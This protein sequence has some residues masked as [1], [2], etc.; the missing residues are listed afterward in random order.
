MADFANTRDSPL[1]GDGIKC[2]DWFAEVNL[3][4]ERG[5][6]M[7]EITRVGVDLAKAVIQVWVPIAI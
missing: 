4:F 2:R 7:S 3:T 1:S 5:G 6:L